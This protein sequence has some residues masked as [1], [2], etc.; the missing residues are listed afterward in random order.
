MSASA[1]GKGS[2][3]HPDGKNT[4]AETKFFDDDEDDDEYAHHSKQAILKLPGEQKGTDNKHKRAGAAAGAAAGS[5]PSPAANRNRGRSASPS[6][7]SSKSNSP[8]LPPASPVP[9]SASAAP[10]KSSSSPPKR[11]GSRGSHGG[12]HGSSKAQSKHG[13]NGSYNGN[14]NQEADPLPDDMKLPMYAFDPLK[15]ENEASQQQQ[16]QQAGGG[17][18]VPLSK[19]LGAYIEVRTDVNDKA[20]FLDPAPGT[21]RR[22][23]SKDHPLAKNGT[24]RYKKELK[25]GIKPAGLHMEIP[26]ELQNRSVSETISVSN[27]VEK[28]TY[29]AQTRIVDPKS[30]MDELKKQQNHALKLIIVEERE[31]EAARDEVLRHLKDPLERKNLEAVSSVTGLGYAVHASVFVP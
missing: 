19:K 28:L 16:Q 4:W 3:Q 13:G 23:F 17:G 9:A 12:G 27:K 14:S 10:K 11:P 2:K 7:G 21:F 1:E 15:S 20:F 5:A 8:R 29:S 24:G 6:G 31:K 18:G 22:E 26:E 25:K 30:K